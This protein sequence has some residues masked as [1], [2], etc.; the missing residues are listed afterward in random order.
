MPSQVEAEMAGLFD[1]MQ[2]VYGIFGFEFHLELSTRPEK[3]LGEVE[4]WNAAED[5]RLSPLT[6]HASY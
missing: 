3:Y 5:V 2:H 6:R 1:F 4:T